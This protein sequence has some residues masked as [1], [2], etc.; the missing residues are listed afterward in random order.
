[1]QLNKHKKSIAAIGS[2]RIREPLENFRE[3]EEA[4]VVSVLEADH[5]EGSSAHLGRE[6]D[7]PCVAWK[8]ERAGKAGGDELP[9]YV[10]EAGKST[11]CCL[12]EIR[13]PQDAPRVLEQRSD[14]NN[15]RKMLRR[16]AADLQKWQAHACFTIG[17]K[18]DDEQ[19]LLLLREIR[20]RATLV[21]LHGMAIVQSCAGTE[22]ASSLPYV[23]VAAFRPEVVCQ[24]D[25]VAESVIPA[26]AR[27]YLPRPFLRFGLGGVWVIG[28]M[29]HYL[30]LF[31]TVEPGTIQGWWHASVPRLCSH[32]S[33]ASERA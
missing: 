11:E 7:S 24:H 4:Q 15:V 31:D 32:P 1:M 18:H 20:S 29:C 13:V 22:D 5:I 33:C 14:L 28:T 16:M 9:S 3:L 12:R 6:S 10:R 23:H 19:N 17:K 30:V 27:V 21:A 2:G 25:W 8:S 26:I